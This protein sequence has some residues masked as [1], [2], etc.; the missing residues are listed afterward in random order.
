MG[1]KNKQKNAKKKKS[2]SSYQSVQ[3]PEQKNKLLYA[4][5]LYTIQSL[6][7]RPIKKYNL[8]VSKNAGDWFSSEDDLSEGLIMRVIE[9]METDN[10]I[11]CGGWKMMY[12]LKS[13][14]LPDNQRFCCYINLC[15]DDERETTH[16]PDLEK[17]EYYHWKETIN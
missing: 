10:P 17:F 5:K 16:P 9:Q 4:R 14:N 11:N 2:K 8:L 7:G 6:L 12:G 15:D 1:Y 3:T 13:T